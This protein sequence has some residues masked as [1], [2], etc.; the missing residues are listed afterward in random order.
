MRVAGC[1]AAIKGELQRSSRPFDS[2][3]FA[4]QGRLDQNEHAQINIVLAQPIC[5]HAELVERHSLV[6]PVENLRMHRFQTH[7]HFQLP[8]QPLSETKA[9]I[10]DQRRMALDDHALETGYPACD[11]ERDLSAGIAFRSKK[12]PLL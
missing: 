8:A 7:R 5:C 6:Q 1:G 11:R 12:L 10:A 4:H 9:V 3:P 2:F